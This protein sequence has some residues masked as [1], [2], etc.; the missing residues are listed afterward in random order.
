M[1]E[2]RVICDNLHHELVQLIKDV[3]DGLLVEVTVRDSLLLVGIVDGEVDVF[4]ER[5]HYLVENLSPEVE[6]EV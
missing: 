5:Q 3:L 2:L 1:S 4:E 6:G